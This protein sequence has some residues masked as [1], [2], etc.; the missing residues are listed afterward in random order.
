MNL[1]DRLEHESR[2]GLHPTASGGQPSV[3][4]MIDNQTASK[5]HW[6]GWDGRELAV[7]GAYRLWRVDRSWLEERAKQLQAEGK[8][9]NWREQRQERF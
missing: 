6:Q 4:V 1:A 5:P 3:L 8:R 7:A 9:P 2:P